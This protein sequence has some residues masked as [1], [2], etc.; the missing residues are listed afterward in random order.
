MRPSLLFHSLKLGLALWA[1]LPCT[2]TVRAA[3]SPET[4]AKPI[5][6]VWRAVGFENT[7]SDY[8]IK[9]GE[10][11]VSLDIP[12]FAASQEYAYTGPNP[13]LIY[14]K[15]D[16]P[17]STQP[18]VPA[19]SIQF[20]PQWTRAL[21]FV[22][23]KADGTLGARTAPNDE[24][25]FKPGSIRIFNLTTEPILLKIG[26]EEQTLASVHETIVT[27]KDH[28][29]LV[30]IRYA[31]RQKDAWAWKGSNYFS[32]P[33]GTRRSVVLIHTDAALFR[34]IGA[35]GEASP[36]TALQIFSFSEQLPSPGENRA[37]K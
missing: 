28:A 24:V 18:P 27:P 36:P 34:A 13:M 35:D 10:H 16:D 31:L 25:H 6:V 23:P 4:D 20:D 21:V 12:A 5:Y 14:R 8:Y 3:S 17:S 32:I 7:L 9:N 22:Y 19:A 37:G 29:R 15:A 26:D 1:A 33:P 2:T 30:P 11:K